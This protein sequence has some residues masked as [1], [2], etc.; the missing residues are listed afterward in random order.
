[1]FKDK[2]YDLVVRYYSLAMSYVPQTAEHIDKL[3]A[4]LLS[5]RC[6]AY[7]NLEEYDQALEDAKRCIQTEPEW[8][9][10]MLYA[11][12]VSGKLGGI[13]LGRFG[14]ESVI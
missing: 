11:F 1:M 12:M 9:K 7:L 8:S 10:V 2:Q 13:H 6:A 5:N 4:V 3:S 14:L